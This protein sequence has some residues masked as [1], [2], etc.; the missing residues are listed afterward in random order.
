MPPKALFHST[1]CPPIPPSNGRN[2]SSL[3]KLQILSVAKD[4][5]C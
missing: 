4:L 5:P 1:H 3:S 2:G